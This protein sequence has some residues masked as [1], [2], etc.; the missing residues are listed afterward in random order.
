[1]MRS[2]QE[3]L[4]R[5]L[6]NQERYHG[7][8]KGYSEAWNTGAESL[9]QYGKPHFLARGPESHPVHELPP[10]LAVGRV[11]VPVYRRDHL[12]GSRRGH[13]REGVRFPGK[14]AGGQIRWT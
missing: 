1:M 7:G 9:H 10:H 3:M 4:R 12:A 14:V 13:T 6:E 8:D 5:I 11:V 2:M